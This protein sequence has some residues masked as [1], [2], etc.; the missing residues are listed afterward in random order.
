M[1]SSEPDI[2]EIGPYGDAK[3]QSKKTWKFRKL[4][5]IQVVSHIEF[6]YHG[7][8]DLFPRPIPAAE[9]EEPEE[10][11]HEEVS[12]VNLEQK[13]SLYAD[14]F[15]LVEEQARSINNTFNG[16]SEADAYHCATE[17][18]AT[19]CITSRFCHRT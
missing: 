8:V 4:S 3:N 14:L 2:R 13:T 17:E 7:V 5:P 10:I 18:S 19:R 15:F 11:Q 9:T 6:E 16:K 1:H 12:S